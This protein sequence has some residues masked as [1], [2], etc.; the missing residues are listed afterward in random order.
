MRIALV[1]P[2]DSSHTLPWVEELALRGHDVFVY[3]YP[4]V[5]VDF[6]PAH[7]STVEGSGPIGRAR[8]LRRQVRADAPDVV[9]QHYVA[10]DA[11]ALSRMDK[12][13]V[14]SVWG[15]DVLRDLTRPL[16]RAVVAWALRSA[17]LVVSPARHMTEVLGGLGVRPERVVT[18]QYGVDTNEFS[19]ASAPASDAP[20]R[21]IC[22]RSLKPVYGHE[23]ILR[24]LPL[25]S[26]DLVSRV[27]FT[28]RGSQAMELKE[29]AEGLAL[30][31]RVS[32]M[33]GVDSMPDALRS[34]AVYC[35]M[36]RS[37]GASL[38][39]LEAMSCGLPVV[40]SDIPANREWID[41][42]RTGVLVPC[43]APDVLAAR[44]SEVAGDQA[45]R[46]RLG[47]AARE[48]VLE[49]GDRAKNVPAIIDAVEQ[50]AVDA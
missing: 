42:G 20:V 12:P 22:T 3:A 11:W 21:V 27:V 14:L 45:L 40:V 24:A 13:L 26:E 46:A 5:T 43:G 25:V 39:L 9:S 18:L 38:S 19:P 1:C 35:S 31:A 10:T 28:G 34:A 16:K 30:G 17:T 4:P 29:L 8:W 37:D 47:D 33:G 49:R 41:E 7:V 50:V 15:S 6:S 32:F 44:L 48:T 23:D 2:G 36:S